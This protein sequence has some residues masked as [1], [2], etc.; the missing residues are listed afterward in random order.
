MTCLILPTEVQCRQS[1]AQKRS[2]SLSAKDT[3]KGWGA[4]LTTEPTTHRSGPHGNSMVKEAQRGSG[5][6]GKQLK[7]AG[8]TRKKFRVLV[9][10]REVEGSNPFES[11]IKSREIQYFTAFLQLFR[12][13]CGP[14]A[15]AFL[16]C[17]PKMSPSSFASLFIFCFDGILPRPFWS[18]R[19][20]T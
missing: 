16:S 9:R 1:K 18:A 15:Q 4:F 5:A 19:S 12:E 20:R 17:F 7:T 10:I 14:V 2:P 3:G 13:S 11:T 8:N 6:E